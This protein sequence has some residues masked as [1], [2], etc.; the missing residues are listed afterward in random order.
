MCLEFPIPISPMCFIVT[1]TVSYA[2]DDDIVIY[3]R[4]KIKQGKKI[5]QSTICVS[6][7][8]KREKKEAEQIKKF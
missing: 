6:C 5:K 2:S 7:V 3:V 1:L 8:Q 4:Q